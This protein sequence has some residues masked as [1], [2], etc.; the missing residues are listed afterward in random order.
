MTR[1]TPGITRGTSTR[2]S[3]DHL[4]HDTT[5]PARTLRS[6]VDHTAEV[7]VI[8]GIACG[9]LPAHTVDPCDLSDVPLERVARSLR[10]LAS[11]GGVRRYVSVRVAGR[12][13]AINDALGEHRVRVAFSVDRI[14][15]ALAATGSPDIPGDR[16]ALEHALAEGV[17]VCGGAAV[18]VHG[19]AVKRSRALELEREL[20]DLLEGAA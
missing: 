10:W 11:N 19:L 8:A 14:D 20:R 9:D 5:K 1:R 17:S 6:L 15:E 4:R 12:E 16:R 18:R 2:V 13:V 7:D 3:P